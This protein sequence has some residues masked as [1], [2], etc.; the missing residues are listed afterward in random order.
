MHLSLLSL[1]ALPAIPLLLLLGWSLAG[2][3]RSVIRREA[4]RPAH[5][6]ALVTCL[7]LADAALCLLFLLNAALSHSGAAQR[8]VP[9]K[10]LASTL[11]LVGVPLGLLLLFRTIA[12]RRE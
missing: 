1:A 11:L 7:V 12:T 4:P 8:A 9:L 5:A 10:C 6:A 2:I 3:I